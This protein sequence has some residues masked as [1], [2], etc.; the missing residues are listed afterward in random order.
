MPKLA[1]NTAGPSAL[2]LFVAE[3][4]AAWSLLESTGA[5]SYSDDSAIHPGFADLP[6][7]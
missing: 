2:F 6:I 7:V 5:A 4:A 1:T 3:A